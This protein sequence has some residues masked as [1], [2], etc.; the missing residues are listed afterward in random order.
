MKYTAG[1]TECAV[2]GETNLISGYDVG[3]IAAPE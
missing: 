3:L 2:P 1:E